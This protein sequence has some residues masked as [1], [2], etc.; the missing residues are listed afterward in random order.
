MHPVAEI[1]RLRQGNRP[2]EDYVTDFLELAYQTPLDEVCLMLFFRG[3]LSEPL[4]SSMPEPNR[5]LI[6]YIEWALSM[7]GSSFAVGLAEEVQVLQVGFIEPVLLTCS[8]ESALHVSHIDPAL[9]M[10]SIEPAL[11]ERLPPN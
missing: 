8:A 4:Y 5:T 10:F 6:Q 3:G 1:M 7:S 11:H 2:I 9:H